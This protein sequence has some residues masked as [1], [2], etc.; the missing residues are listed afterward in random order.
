MLLIYIIAHFINFC[1]NFS[2]EIIQNSPV[3]NPK[4]I[5][6]EIS[7]KLNISEKAIR[8]AV[9]IRQ[10]KKS[11]AISIASLRR[12]FLKIFFNRDKSG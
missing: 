10:N 5:K 8:D 4:R 12:L 9:K 1:N 6:N 2:I 7:G 11:A 3:K